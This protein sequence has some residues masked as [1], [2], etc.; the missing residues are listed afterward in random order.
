MDL[1]RRIVRPRK[2]KLLMQTE[3]L[4]ELGTGEI[5]CRLGYLKYGIY[6]RT[7][8]TINDVLKI[9]CVK[10]RKCVM[11]CNICFFVIQATKIFG[12]YEM[13]CVR[14]ESSTDFNMP[15]RGCCTTRSPFRMVGIEES[16]NQPHRIFLWYIFLQIP[17]TYHI[18]SFTLKIMWRFLIWHLPIF[19]MVGST[20]SFEL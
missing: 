19:Q 15:W 2:H 13:W 6:Q 9:V 5:S 12:T 8:A 1:T 16:T 17:D 20:I 10:L 14:V 18:S 3:V 11:L 7:I 4:G